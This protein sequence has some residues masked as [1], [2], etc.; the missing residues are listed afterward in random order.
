MPSFTTALAAFSLASSAMAHMSPF[1]RELFIAP[2]RCV[3]LIRRFLASMYG[4]GWKAYGND[5]DFQSLDGEPLL[6]GRDASVADYRLTAGD[7]FVPLGPEWQQNDWWFRGPAARALPPAPGAVAHLPAGGTF[8]MEIACHFAWTSYGYA[9]TDPDSLLSACPG[10]S[11]KRLSPKRTPKG[12]PKLIPVLFLGAYHSGDPNDNFIT[13]SMLSGCAL[14]IA[15]V[16]SIDK[17]RVSSSVAERC[18]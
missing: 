15:D 1:L 2:H 12:G 13:E 8:T 6:V 11:G 5:Y 9:T 18:R 4:V 3:L 16:D 17:V 7:P 10:N 14:G